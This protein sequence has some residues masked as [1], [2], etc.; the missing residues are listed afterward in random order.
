MLLIKNTKTTKSYDKGKALE[1]LAY[2]F[3]DCIEGI[4]VIDRNIRN[5]TE[6][7]DLCFCNFTNDSSFWKMGPI[8]LV[9]CKNHSRKISAKTIRNLNSIME[10][11]GIT[12]SILFTSST[13]TKPALEEIQKA[14]NLNKHI[15][16]F[17]VQDL[18]NNLDRSPHIILEEKI[19][20]EY[21]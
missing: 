16:V 7:L 14:K 9:E 15:I 13:L 19:R 6:E 20:R 5:S 8:V 12:T 18:I 11:K 3:F 4:K 17:Y 1:D 21:E 10:A 2:Y